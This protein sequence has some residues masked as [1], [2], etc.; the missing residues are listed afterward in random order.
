M[1]RAGRIRRCQR[2]G[3]CGQ[4]RLISARRTDDYGA[5]AAAAAMAAMACKAERRL[6]LEVEIEIENGP[7]LNSETCVKCRLYSSETIQGS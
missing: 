2:G 5:E 3:G 1:K 6:G 7:D 4:T